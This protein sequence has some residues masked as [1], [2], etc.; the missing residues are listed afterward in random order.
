[1]KSEGTLHCETRTLQISGWPD[2][3]RTPGPVGCLEARLEV[4]DGVGAQGDI[5][6]TRLIGVPTMHSLRVQLVDDDEHDYDNSNGDIHRLRQPLDKSQFH[7]LI[8]SLFNCRSEKVHGQ[9]CTQNT[10][11]HT[12]TH[13]H[14][15]INTCDTHTRSTRRLQTQKVASNGPT[16]HRGPIYYMW[17]KASSSWVQ[18]LT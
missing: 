6:A 1:M 15:W 17:T 5:P 12:H 10:H 18:T 16:Y 11:T 2:A 7:D 13:A 14:A 8:I 9:I 4:A 3:I